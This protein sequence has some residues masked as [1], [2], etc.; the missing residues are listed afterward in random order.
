MTALRQIEFAR[1]LDVNRSYVTR[2]KQD[3]RIVLTADG[4]VDVEASRARIL[5]TAGGRDDVAARW[6][7]AKGQTPAS[8]PPA[9]PGGQENGGEGEGEARTT[10]ADAMAR[11]EHYLALQAKLDYEKAAGTVVVKTDV[12]E[13]FADV[14]VLFRQLVENQA[15]RLAAQLVQK[16]LDFVRGVIRQDGQEMIQAVWQEADRRMKQMQESA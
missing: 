13:T 5:A 9:P 7:R 2:L 16:D 10:R 6:A 3:G 1:H 11:K 4:L 14:M 8:G 15:H 12:E